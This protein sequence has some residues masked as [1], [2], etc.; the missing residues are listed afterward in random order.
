MGKARVT[1][2]ICDNP[3]CDNQVVHTTAEPALGYHLSGQVHLSDISVKLPKTYACSTACIG[4]AVHAKA[5][6]QLPPMDDEDEVPQ[7]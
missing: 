4:A 1:I 7:P 5:V 2:Y 6:E 3:E